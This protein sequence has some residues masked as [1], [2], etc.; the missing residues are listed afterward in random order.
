MTEVKVIIGVDHREVSEAAFDW[1]IDHA[2]QS[3]H[4]CIAVYCTDLE[5]AVSRR[6]SSVS[7]D[8]DDATVLN[9]HQAHQKDVQQKFTRK[10]REKRV[11]GCLRLVSGKPGQCLVRL[12]EEEDALFVVMGAR[13]GI[14]GKLRRTFSSSV[15]DY[16]LHHAP[17]P[18]F[19]Y[20]K[21]D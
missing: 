11:D 2:H 15:S 9:K 10:I 5:T 18:V 16:V 13:G 3:H 6:P 8:Y 14:R 1:Y 12:A 20:K 21:K 4:R 19:I 7:E 17:C